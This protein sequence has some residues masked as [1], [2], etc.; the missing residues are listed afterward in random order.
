MILL[1][2]SP[3]KFLVRKIESWN[4]LRKKVS[5]R[6][7]RGFWDSLALPAYSG[8]CRGIL[9]LWE[10]S[11]PCQFGSHALRV[12]IVH[13]VMPWLCLC[14]GEHC[15][16]PFPIRD[17]VIHGLRFRTTIA[18]QP[19]FQLLGH[20][21]IYHLTAEDMG[22]WM[23]KRLHHGTDLEPLFC[24]SWSKCNIDSLCTVEEMSISVNVYLVAGASDSFNHL[25]RERCKKKMYVQISAGNNH[26]HSF[27]I[28][29]KR[30][31]NKIWKYI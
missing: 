19:H 14:V 7:N 15:C 24:L 1:I 31:M 27:D 21:Y 3:S 20:G 17:P 26:E 11:Q 8:R 25:V 6:T 28:F 22:A 9:K 16:K 10:C 12:L 30:Y 5:W 13:K 2:F 23:G 4:N 29:G 18:T